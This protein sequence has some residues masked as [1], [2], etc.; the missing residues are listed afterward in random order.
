[1]SALQG[2]PSKRYAILVGVVMTLGGY[3]KAHRVSVHGLFSITLDKYSNT[4]QMESL[5]WAK[6]RFL[7]QDARSQCHRVRAIALLL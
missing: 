6:I 1:M 3:D 7:Q 4:T 5:S 2:L